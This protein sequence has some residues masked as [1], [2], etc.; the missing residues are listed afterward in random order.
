MEYGRRFFEE[1]SHLGELQG[2]HILSSIKGG[3]NKI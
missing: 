2:F 1:V 3:E